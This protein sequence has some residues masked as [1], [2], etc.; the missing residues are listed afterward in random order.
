MTLVTLASTGPASSS[1]LDL[2]QTIN[3]CL[4]MGFLIDAAYSNWDGPK[5]YMKQF[6]TLVSFGARVEFQRRK[7]S[8]LVALLVTLLIC[9]PQSRSSVTVIH[10]Y[11]AEETFYKTWL[12]RYQSWIICFGRVCFIT[13]IEWHLATLNLMIHASSHWANLFKSSWSICWS[14]DL[15]IFR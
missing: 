15:L 1:P 4:V 3:F 9:W 5:L 13:L 7:P 12:F 11:F 8:V 6:A 2:L 14:S 10:K